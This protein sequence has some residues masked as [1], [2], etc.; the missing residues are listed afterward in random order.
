MLF[1]YEITS[2]L[3]VRILTEHERILPNEEFF[4]EIATRN[5]VI[6]C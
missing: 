3:K 6:T 2:G 5:L 1:S 4:V